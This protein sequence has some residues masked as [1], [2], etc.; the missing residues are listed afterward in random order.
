MLSKT[1]TIGGVER[2]LCIDLNATILLSLIGK[3]IDETVRVLVKSGVSLVEKMRAVRVLVWA[4]SACEHPEFEEDLSTVREVGTWFDVSDLPVVTLALIEIFSD[5]A[6]C[7]M[8]ANG[9]SMTEFD[10]QLAPF[11]PTP[12]SVVAAMIAAAKL[13]PGNVVL[14][15]GAGDGRLLFAAIEQPDVYAIG[16]E[17]QSERYGKLQSA[18]NE[19]AARSRIVLHNVDLAEADLSQ[20]DAVFIYLLPASNEKLKGWLRSGMKPGARL[21]SHDFTM[22][23]WEPSETI[24]VSAQ[25]RDHTVYVWIIPERAGERETQPVAVAEVGQ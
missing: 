5:Y 3:D 14:D 11:V 24:R 2:K 7:V 20:A 22:E 23:G 17:R 21:I 16:Y 13:R 18:R 10:G 4:L 15:L 8:A 9:I 6:N 19:H 25:D 12:A 1:I